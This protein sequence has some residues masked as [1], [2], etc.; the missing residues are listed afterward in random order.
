MISELGTKLEDPSSAVHDVC[1]PLETSM[2]DPVMRGSEDRGKGGRVTVRSGGPERTPGE[3]VGRVIVSVWP[4]KDAVHGQRVTSG[5]SCDSDNEIRPDGTAIDDRPSVSDSGPKENGPAGTSV[6]RVT[7]VVPYPYPSG[8]GKVGV[9]PASV[10]AG[11]DASSGETMTAVVK[12]MVV[13]GIPFT[14]GTVYVRVRSD[15]TGSPPK[16]VKGAG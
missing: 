8:T 15:K 5:G 14:L 16:T 12:V 10:A 9:G 3:V 2:E 6:V 13:S 11:R 4:I 7:S 1:S